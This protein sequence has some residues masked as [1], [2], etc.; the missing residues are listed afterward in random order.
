[1][2]TYWLIF[3]TVINQYITAL[4]SGKTIFNHDYPAM[5]SGFSFVFLT[6]TTE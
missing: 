4:S 6:K 3:S 2:T 1:M 5:K